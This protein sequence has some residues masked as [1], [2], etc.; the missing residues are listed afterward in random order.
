MEH[1]HSFLPDEQQNTPLNARITVLRSTEGKHLSKKIYPDQVAPY[2]RATFFEP[3]SVVI[4]GFDDLV[5]LLRA[6]E[7]RTDSIVVQGSVTDDA[8]SQSVIRRLIHDK[9]DAKA[10]LVDAGSNLLNFD[11]DDLEF[12]DTLGWHDPTSL[13][14]WV[15][16]GIVERLPDL[17]GAN[18]FWQASSR[19]GTAGV[20]HLAKFHF[21]CLSSRTLRADE[22][23][24]IYLK[25]GA[26]ES[27]AGA[28]QPH[29]IARPAF[30]N[31][32]DPLAG[33]PRS[34]VF[35]GGQDWAEIS[36]PAVVQKKSDKQNHPSPRPTPRT[37][38]P[39]RLS[40]ST[41]QFGRKAL[42]AAERKI[43]AA[44]QRNTTIYTQS[45]Y[46]GGLV[47]GGVVAL[48]DAEDVLL[49]AGEA[50]GHRRYAQAV[51][52]GLA[53]G[54]LRPI[55]ISEHPSEISPFHDAPSERRADAIQ[56]HG[57]IIR[58]WG[59]RAIA[60]ARAAKAAME[61]HL[62]SDLEAADG[63]E[64]PTL[65]CPREMLTGAQGVGK[66]A[67]LVGRNGRSDV[68]HDATGLVTLMLLPG[69]AKVAEACED[70]QRNADDDAPKAIILR[71]RGQEDPNQPGQQMCRVTGLAAKLSRQGL[72]VRGHLCTKC[73]FRQTCGYLHQEKQIKRSA[74]SS[75]GAVIFA[76]H[77]YAHYPLP[78]QVR[79]DQVVFDER[80][81]DLGVEII[82]LDPS[83][84]RED[85]EYHGEPWLRSPSKAEEARLEALFYQFSAIRPL[86][87]AILAAIQ[88]DP[89]RLLHG[90]RC[91]DVSKDLIET[92]LEGLDCF[93][94]WDVS[95][96]VHAAC[97]RATA[98]A[99]AQSA[100]KAL[101]AAQHQLS[102]LPDSNLKKLQ[103]LFEALLLQID[104]D[105]DAAEG[106]EIE[107]TNGEGCVIYVSRI[108]PIVH[109]EQTPLLHLDGTGEIEIARALFGSDLI[110]HH[111]P[112]ER[113][114]CFTQIVGTQFSK[115]RI[116]GHSSRVI[117][118][119][120]AN[121]DTNRFR[122]YVR[123]VVG[124]IP[125]AAV[126]ACRP[127]LEALG[128]DGE[129]RAGHFGNLRGRN[130]WEE[131][132]S[133]III[134]REQPSPRDVERIARA[135]AAQAGDTLKPSEYVPTWRGI[136]TRDGAVPL[137]V[138][139]HPDPWADRVLRQIRE[140]EIEQAV[141]RIRLIHNTS[142]KTVYLLSPV[143]ID[144]TI[145]QVVT[146]KDFKNGG[147]RIERA[148]HKYRFLPL[149]VR[150]RSR[151]MPDLWP[152]PELSRKDGEAVR[153]LS[154]QAEGKDLLD[155]CDTKPLGRVR[156]KRVTQPGK[157]EAKQEAVIFVS[158]ETARE[159]I[160]KTVGELALF[161]VLTERA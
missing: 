92:A 154:D 101:A 146:W 34:G 147:T 54:Q 112:V 159:M 158:A 1:K 124:R 42:R 108:R 123:E 50:S 61:G 22:R 89:D 155:E 83:V 29:Y 9:P 118:D 70:F 97:K 66:T 62:P 13:A 114:A 94:P 126:F 55:S 18:V 35:E 24:E 32:V 15:W 139:T 31:V 6:L 58:D 87:Q 78:G 104:R 27:L 14:Q 125:E 56:R 141:D 72:S 119:E 73:P 140:A 81:R 100:S 8:R 134:G 23:K 25:T 111:V 149:S 65:S 88:D 122:R 131:Y 69:H 143:A 26:D 110:H 45:Y 144:A 67:A 76:P 142:P 44:A 84:L 40:T 33:L 103:I 4:G 161:E 138:M 132:P 63:V 113:N 57:D 85:L 115:S 46:I 99:S 75:Q 80:P 157:R 90:L 16:D 127:V 43:L 21:W 121:E 64:P 74:A 17:R 160:E 68:L 77:D 96:T 106:I 28:A 11:I 145:D 30:I 150:E 7:Q 82:D 117:A 20:A 130:T 120:D 148:I 129:E 12:P 151:V 39:T 51:E 60:Y 37:P 47:A 152:N 36:P 41:S 10:T 153:L 116:C 38:A 133:A 5:T 71:G 86:Q 109:G 135:F 102:L 49:R 105:S 52:N 93:Q 3:K 19:A 95:S 48:S 136:R 79:P 53:A 128:L 137:E 156:Y 2:D 107:D 91:R 98:H 59:R